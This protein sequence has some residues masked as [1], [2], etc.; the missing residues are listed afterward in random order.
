MAFNVRRAPTFGASTHKESPLEIAM[1]VCTPTRLAAACATALSLFAGAAF[2]QVPA[3]YP[4]D[5]Q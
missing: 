1:T 4:A 2:A 5:Y 3:G